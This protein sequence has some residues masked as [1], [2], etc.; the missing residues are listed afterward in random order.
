MP[1][2][3]VTANPPPPP[4]STIPACCASIDCACR[5]VTRSI[6]RTPGR[7]SSTCTCSRRTADCA[8]S[9]AIETASAA[10]IAVLRRAAL[11]AGVTIRVIYRAELR[12]RLE[13]PR[14]FP[15]SHDRRD[16]RRRLR[17]CIE[18]AAAARRLL[19][20]RRGE[21]AQVI[22]R[23]QTARPSELVRVVER[24]ARC[25]RHVDVEAL[26][27]VNPFLTPCTGLDDP[28]GLDLER[29][30]VELAHLRRH[31]VDLRER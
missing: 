18:L 28:A 14:R 29:G 1:S 25:P 10:V 19:R 27:L 20:R 8:A 12:L 3:D 9:G 23:L 5:A 24:F 13:Y 11:L 26:R 6:S 16:M 30:R 21:R 22:R 7:D 17:H 15:F 31:A 4:P 2:N